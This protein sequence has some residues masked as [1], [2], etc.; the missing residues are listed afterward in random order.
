MLTQSPAPDVAA[1]PPPAGYRLYRD[2]VGWSVAVPEGWRAARTGTTATFRDGDRVLT[3]SHHGNPPQDPYAAQLEQEPT[4]EARTAGYDLMRIA[5]VS[6]RNWPTADWEYRSGTGPVLH[7]L[8]RSTVPTAD[9]AYDISWTTPDRS[10]SADR[11]FF[12]NATR[13]FAPGA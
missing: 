13:T 7:T 10:W 11:T 3:V 5:R 12:D 8:V 9:L 6:Y 2:P 4:V 1:A